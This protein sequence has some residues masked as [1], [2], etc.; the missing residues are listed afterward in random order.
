MPFLLPS[1]GAGLIFRLT[2]SLLRFLLRFSPGD[3]GI[4]RSAIR[5]SVP[6]RSFEGFNERQITHLIG[7]QP[8]SESQK[9]SDGFGH[10]L[11]RLHRECPK[12]YI[13]IVVQERER[14]GKNRKARSTLKSHI[15]IL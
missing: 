15:L 10:S 3:C 6:L 13:I 8:V 5:D 11:W 7:A 1:I 9:V 4:V 12:T 14:G 2:Y